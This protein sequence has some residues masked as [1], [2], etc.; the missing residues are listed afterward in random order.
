MCNILVRK[1]YFSK[2]KFYF[3]YTLYE[4]VSSDGIDRFQACKW[5]EHG[6]N[7]LCRLMPFRHEHSRSEWMNVMR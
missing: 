7:Y 1:I 5:D 6:W 4:N 3:D 2:T